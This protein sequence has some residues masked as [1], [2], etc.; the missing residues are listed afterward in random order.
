MV[1]AASAFILADG[2]AAQR[3]D[4]NVNPYGDPIWQQPEPGKS[5]GRRH[6][7]RAPPHV[8]HAKRTHAKPRAHVG[9]GRSKARS[10]RQHSV[11]KPLNIIPPAARGR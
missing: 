2:A 9:L 4:I 1:V 7:R 8:K 11:G 5:K 3:D 6:V 10:T